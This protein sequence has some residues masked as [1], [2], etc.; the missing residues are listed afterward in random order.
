MQK[1]LPY[2]AIIIVLLYAFYNARSNTDN[3][4]I[5]KNPVNSKYVN[6]VRTHKETHLQEEL[7]RVHTNAYLKQYIVNVI[8]HGS[9]QFDFKGGVME[10]GFASK[11]DAPKIACFVLELSGKKCASPYPE[12]AAMYYSSNCAGCHGEDG[13]GLN[14][15]YPDL[16]RPVLLGIEKK[17]SFLENMLESMH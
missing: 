12:D 17:T 8:N 5:K 13:K 11:E 6:H 3:K 14:G 4:N 7:S 1:N 9:E 10:G 15:T 16:T 2:F